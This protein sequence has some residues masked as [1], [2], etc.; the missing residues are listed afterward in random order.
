MLK[1][2]RLSPRITVGNRLRIGPKKWNQGGRRDQSL[3]CPS[4]RPSIQSRARPTDSPSRL[5][6]TQNKYCVGCYDIYSIHSHFKENHKRGAAAEGRAT[7]VVAMNRVDVVAVNTIFVLRFSKTGQTV[8]R[9]D[10]RLD[11]CFVGLTPLY[12]CLLYTSDA[13]DE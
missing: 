4:D 9:T 3:V 5:T 2:S 13:A 6:E 10:S 1:Y 7:F 11:G 12:T 8:G